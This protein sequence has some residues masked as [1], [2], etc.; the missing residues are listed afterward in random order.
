MEFSERNMVY[1]IFFEL[2][3]IGYAEIIEFMGMQLW[4]SDNDE[5]EYVNEGT[6]DEDYEDL[7]DFIRKRATIICKELSKLDFQNGV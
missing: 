2:R 7:E 6:P 1:G 3:S 5:R 4:N